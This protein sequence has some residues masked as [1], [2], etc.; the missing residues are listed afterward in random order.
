[1]QNS[2][3]FPVVKISVKNSYCTYHTNV[4]THSIST[5]LDRRVAYSRLSSKSMWLND[6]ES[7]ALN[8]KINLRI[9]SNCRQLEHTF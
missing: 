8:S 1:M 7:I 4:D 6:V 5:Y 9:A 2:D 3:F